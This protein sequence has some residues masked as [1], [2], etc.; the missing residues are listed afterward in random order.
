[1]GLNS[2]VSMR[3]LHKS[4][5]FRVQGR[6]LEEPRTGFLLFC[7]KSVRSNKTSYCSSDDSINNIDGMDRRSINRNSHSHRS[8]TAIRRVNHDTEH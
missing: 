5:G 4:F 7:R 3:V 1:M 8:Q 6:R 2:R